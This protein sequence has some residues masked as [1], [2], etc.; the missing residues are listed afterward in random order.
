MSDPKRGGFR[1][2]LLASVV[3]RL[4]RRVPAPKEEGRHVPLRPGEPP[5]TVERELPATAGSERLTL[6]ALGLTV[7]GAA[8]FMVFYVA[9][10]DTQLL[11]LCLGL[12]FVF[13]AVACI[14]AGKKLVPQEK[15]LEEYHEFGDP[16]RQLEVAEM[17]RRGGDGIS[18]RKMLLGAA[19]AAGGTV[20]VAATFPLASLGPRVDDILHETPWKSGRRVV[21]AEGKPLTADDVKEEEFRTGFPEGAS[22]HELGSPIILVRLPLDEIEVPPDRKAKMPEGIIGFSKICTHAGCAISMYRYP[23]FS[24][25]QPA[26]ALVCPCHYSTFDVRRGGE[27]I[28]GPAGRSLPILPLRLNDARELVADGD[29]FGNVGPSWSGVRQ[30]GGKT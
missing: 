27:V 19:G 29:F 26:P 10:P 5:P 25:T 11:G 22:Q 18:R 24:D 8:G 16:E 12:A 13:A 2:W 28:F 15:V 9:F 7:L 23:T 17:V 14:V 4:L 1:D 3:V 30:E 6:A 21:D 20:G